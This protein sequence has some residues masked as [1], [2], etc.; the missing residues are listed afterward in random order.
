MIEYVR[1]CAMQGE[2]ED[3]AQW[4][5]SNGELGNRSQCYAS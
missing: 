4:S 2:A 3:P 1:P 5:R